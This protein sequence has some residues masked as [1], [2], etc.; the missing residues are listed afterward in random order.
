MASAIWMVKKE[1]ATLAGQI[2]MVLLSGHLEAV[3]VQAT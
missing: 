3:S 2:K 1:A